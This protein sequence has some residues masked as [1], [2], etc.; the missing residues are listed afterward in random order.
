M[1][2]KRGGRRRSPSLCPAQISIFGRNYDNKETHTL[3]FTSQ[4]SSEKRLDWETQRRQYTSIKASTF[5][6]PDSNSCVYLWRFCSAASLS[7]GGYP[8]RRSAKLRVSFFDMGVSLR[9]MRVSP[10]PSPETPHAPKELES[11]ISSSATSEPKILY[12]INTYSH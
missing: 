10:S 4:K 8:V 3:V 1:R 5:F 7:V 6:L 12:N 9:S 11:L 2:N